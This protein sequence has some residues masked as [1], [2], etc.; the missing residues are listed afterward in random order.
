[1]KEIKQSHFKFRN[2]KLFWRKIQFNEQK[3]QRGDQRKKMEKT[4]ERKEV[5][6]GLF[7]VDWEE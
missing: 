5:N 7:I 6:A 4:K 1:M 2:A 3:N